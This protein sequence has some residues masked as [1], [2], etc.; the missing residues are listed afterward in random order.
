MPAGLTYPQEGGCLCGAVRFSLNAPPRRIGWCHC[1]SCRKHSG[2]PAAAFADCARADL[3]FTKGAV[4]LYAS[5]PGVRRG[6]CAVCGSTLSYESDKR[7]DEIDLH[8]GAFDNAR[9]F[10]PN[11]PATFPDERL[12]WVP[13]GDSAA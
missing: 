2:A 11:A 7:A 9:L 13:V 12:P 3:K 10:G 6:F 4:T 5:S 1:Q 8:I